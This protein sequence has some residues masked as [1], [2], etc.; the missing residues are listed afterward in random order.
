[1]DSKLFQKLDEKKKELD[2]L[3]PFPREILKEN[4]KYD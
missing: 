4:I 3:R 1:M 2:K